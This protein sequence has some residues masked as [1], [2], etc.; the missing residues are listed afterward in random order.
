[1]RIC[2]RPMV[3]ISHVCMYLISSKYSR[4]HYTHTHTHT[5]TPGMQ[6]TNKTLQIYRDFLYPR[7][8]EF[9]MRDLVEDNASPHNND[10]IRA[11]HKTHDIRIVGY[12]ASDVEKQ[13]IKRLIDV[14]TR[15][16]RCPLKPTCAHTRELP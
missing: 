7:M 2:D 4:E 13:A 15:A 16:Y 10:I 14:Q 3:S 9:G 5:H 6:D 1:M 8:R 11:S 12:D